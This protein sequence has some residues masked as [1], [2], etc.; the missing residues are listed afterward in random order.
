MAV[1]NVTWEAESS[2]SLASTLS[3]TVASALGSAARR[4]ANVSVPPSSSTMM[5]LMNTTSF[6]SAIVVA[7]STYVATPPF[8]TNDGTVMSSASG[9]VMWNAA[10]ASG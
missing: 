10:R 1:E 9:S 6:V 2:S 3:D 7:F 4:M 8:V 5:V